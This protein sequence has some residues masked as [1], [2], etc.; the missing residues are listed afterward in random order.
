MLC[1]LLRPSAGR[2]MVAG[3]D[4]V[5]R[6][7]E[8]RRR[9]GLVFQGTTLDDYLTAPPALSR[10]LDPGISWGGWLLPTAAELSLVALVA[11]GALALASA[12]FSHTE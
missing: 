6:Q 12:R 8:V 10:L 5:Q 4:V 9:I 2:A 11:A 3:F 1:T 7:A